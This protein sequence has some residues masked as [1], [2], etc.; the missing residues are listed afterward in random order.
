MAAGEEKSE[1]GLVLVGCDWVQARCLGNIRPDPVQTGPCTLI[2]SQRSR[3]LR[4]FDHR[5]QVIA[6]T[7]MYNVLRK[8]LARELF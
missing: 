4:H 6:I 5:L 2:V 1:Y 8:V 3:Q 7:I